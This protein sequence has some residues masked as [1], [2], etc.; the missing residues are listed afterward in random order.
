MGARLKVTDLGVVV[1]Q[2]EGHGGEVEDAG[3]VDAA[4][5]TQV[6]RQ[7]VLLGDERGARVVVQPL[8]WVHRVVVGR[9]E[10]RRAPPQVPVVVALRTTT[11]NE[12]KYCI[13]FVYIA[14]YSISKS[15]GLK[16]LYNWRCYGGH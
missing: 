14:Q 8:P 7:A 5:A 11:K 16:A 13:N 10:P 9:A 3:A 4:H 2:V 1:R 6:A 12:T 15:I